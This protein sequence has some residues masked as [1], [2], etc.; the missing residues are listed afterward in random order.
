MMLRLRVF[1]FRTLSPLYTMKITVSIM[2][3]KLQ[4]LV[5]TCSKAMV[6]VLFPSTPEGYNTSPSLTVAY[7]GSCEEGKNFLNDP[8]FQVILICRS[9]L[10]IIENRCDKTGTQ[11]WLPTNIT[12]GALKKILV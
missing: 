2:V 9:T 4:K 12:R 10:T 6:G 7:Y 1:I 11:F 8:Q 5:T 3:S